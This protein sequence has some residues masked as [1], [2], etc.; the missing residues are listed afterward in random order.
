[1]RRIDYDDYHVFVGR[2]PRPRDDVEVDAVAGRDA[3]V[4]RVTGPRPGPTCK[5]IA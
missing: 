3:R 4:H 1:V 2:I 5:A